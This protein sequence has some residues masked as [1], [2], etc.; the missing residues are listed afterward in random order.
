MPARLPGTRDDPT[1]QRRTWPAAGHQSVK[2]RFA[3]W[4]MH[5]DRSNRFGSIDVAKRYFTT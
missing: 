2:Y 1:C 3:T 5:K 4:M